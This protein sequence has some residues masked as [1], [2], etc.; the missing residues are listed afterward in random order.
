MN[1]VYEPENHDFMCRIR[2]AKIAGIAADIRAAD[3]GPT[4]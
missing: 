1:Y 3:S 4:F 2:A